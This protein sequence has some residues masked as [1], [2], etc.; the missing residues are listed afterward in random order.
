MTIQFCV[1]ASGSSGN[2]TLVRVE[3][4][5]GPSHLLVDAGLSPRATKHRLAP[6]G[7]DLRDVD[8]ILLTH[9]DTDHYHRGWNRMLTRLHRP[10][11]LHLQH[12]RHAIRVGMPLDR[13]A[14]FDAP[15]QTRHGVGVAGTLLSHDH[16]GTVGFV[17][18][19]GGRRLGHAT[20]LGHVPA[21]L[22]NH[23]VELDALA[24]E[25]NY[26]RR[27]QLDSG[28]PEFLKRRIM[29]SRGHL[30]NE[31]ALKAVV[32]I[33][34][35]S[36]LSHIVLLHLSRDCNDPAHVR[37]LYEREAP[38]LVDRLTISDQREP[39]D[40]LTVRRGERLAPPGQMALFARG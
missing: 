28:R 17:V 14:P 11:H 32:H 39:T 3:T 30:S 5:Q 38:Q 6:L 7:L 24:F 10:V 35:R 12:R 21:S 15:F 16:L 31:A 40:L 37:R 23:F 27:M 8:D 9:L 29:G 20:D 26:D 13:I 25:S 2:C 1:L 33:A 4:D 34:Q 18:E 36:S 22:L 19:H